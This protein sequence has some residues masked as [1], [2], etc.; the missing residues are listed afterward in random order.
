[1]EKMG[2]WW[3]FRHVHFCMFSERKR[4]TFPVGF[5]EWSRAQPSLWRCCDICSRDNDESCDMEKFWDFWK[6]VLKFGVLH[7]RIWLVLWIK[8]YRKILQRGSLLWRVKKLSNIG[9]HIQWVLFSPNTA[10]WKQSFL[11]HCVYPGRRDSELL[12]GRKHGE[13]EEALRTK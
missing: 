12:N 5:G 9:V 2:A 4:R 11:I 6:K 8:I 13:T 3:H 1:M 7:K 10:F